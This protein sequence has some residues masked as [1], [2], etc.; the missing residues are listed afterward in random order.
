MS[1]VNYRI[2]VATFSVVREASVSGPLGRALISEPAEAARVARELIPDDGK[3]HFGAFYLTSQN[4]LI[5]YHEV[6]MGTVNACLVTSKEVFGPAL[7]LLGVNG[8]ILVHCHPSGE[9]TPSQDDLRLTRK[10]VE[11]GKLLELNV[12]DHIIIGNGTEAYVSLAQRGA[13]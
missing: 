2:K 9:A 4:R 8:L 12:L 5:A 11:A 10:L 6:G 3:E 13:I 7:R 1:P